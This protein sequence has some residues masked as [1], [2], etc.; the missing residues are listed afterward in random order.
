[1]S[2]NENAARVLVIGGG[3]GG[4]VAAIR[5]AQLGGKVTL[6]ERDKLGGTCLNRGCIPTKALLKSTSFFATAK[7]AADMGVNLKVE[8]YDL[9]K[10]RER[11]NR[12]VTQ[13]V[14]GVQFL[15]K[16]NQIQLIEGNA[17]FV[18]PGAVE[19]TTKDGHALSY[20][21]CKIIVATGSKPAKLTLPGCDNQKVITSDDALKLE[22]I[23][24]KIAVIGGGAVGI[25]FALIYRNMGAEVTLLEMLPQLMPQM[26]AETVSVLEKSMKNRGITIYTGTRVDRI[27]DVPNG[28]ALSIDSPSGSKKL[29]VGQVLV[30]VGRVANTEG[31]ELDIS[32]IKTERGKIVVN[33]FL[34]TSMPGVYAIG[35]VIGGIQLAHVASAEGITAAEN[36]LGGRSPIN[37]KVVP[38]CVYS[39]PEMAGVGLTEKQA[40]DQG[41]K[42]KVGKFNFTGSGKAI[43]VGATVGLAKVIADEKYGEILGVHI[44]G[45]RATDLIAEA[46]L[47]MK[48]EATV[49]EV[50]STIHAHPT[51]SETLLE[52][53]LAVHGRSIHS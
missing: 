38:G 9:A 27:E 1:M 20:K 10:I 8:G 19:I 11:K 40:R 17:K 46:A 15:V 14:N 33:E 49:D 41:Y 43:A 22:S 44:I 51:M 34:E 39:I 18:G 52:A 53:A 36:A 30:A 28:V 50:T 7:E 23:P 21:D 29:E 42:V 16:K 37:Y 24:E 48:L 35:D 25:E 32:G 31:L 2:T 5:A 12:V 45:E 3:P 6:V 4:Y 47:A 13:L 26:D